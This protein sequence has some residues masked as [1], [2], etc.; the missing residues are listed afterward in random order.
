[1]LKL[2][3]SSLSRMTGLM[4]NVMDLARARFGGRYQPP[5]GRRGLGVESLQRR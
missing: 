3:K 2:M 4:E 5:K 1:M